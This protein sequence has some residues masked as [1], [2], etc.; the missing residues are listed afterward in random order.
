MFADSENPLIPKFEFYLFEIINNNLR[1]KRI[2]KVN[3]TKSL[4]LRA[5]QYAEEKWKEAKNKENEERLKAEQEA[6]EKAEE[7]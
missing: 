4:K 6:A 5:F 3:V 7:G 2:N 1:L